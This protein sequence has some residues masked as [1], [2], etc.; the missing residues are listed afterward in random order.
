MSA[1]GLAEIRLTRRVRL[2]NFFA[3]HRVV[4]GSPT[5]DVSGHSMP[6]LLYFDML[7]CSLFGLYRPSRI[8]FFPCVTG[9][10]FL[11]TL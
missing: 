11:I 5:R 10:S 7:L 9:H 8:L 3:R 6:G 2:V 4:F 1:H